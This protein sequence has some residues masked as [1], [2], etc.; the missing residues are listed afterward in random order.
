M[1]ENKAIPKLILCGDSSVGKTTLLSALN[2]LQPG[3]TTPTMPVGFGSV[4]L[5]H[6][7]K[8]QT[9]NVWDTAGQEIYRS[10]IQMYFRGV[11]VALV[12]YDVSL[13]ETFDHIS[14]WVAQVEENSGNE[15]R[16]IIIV[17]NKIDVE[18]K[19]VMTDE[20]ITTAKYCNAQFVEV[21]AITSEG[22]DSLISLILNQY[23]IIVQE[24]LDLLVA[25]QDD[26]NPVKVDSQDNINSGKSS[27]CC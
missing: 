5:S 20:L 12:V 4:T 17:G 16:A 7:N 14:E 25:Q 22:I 19:M 21:S 1:S 23:D 13:H 18:Q 15:K 9:F 10:L 24:R 26:S 27:D 3:N 8:S 6:G 11:D 2:R